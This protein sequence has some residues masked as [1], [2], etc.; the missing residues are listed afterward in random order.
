[1]LIMS[2]ISWAIARIINARAA[3]IAFEADDT[4]GVKNNI[5]R[6]IRYEGKCSLADS[7]REHVI[8]ITNSS[9]SKPS[10]VSVHANIISEFRKLISVVCVNKI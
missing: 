9:D 4:N 3:Y 7:T 10:V 5:V 6:V 1:M 2:I 8:I